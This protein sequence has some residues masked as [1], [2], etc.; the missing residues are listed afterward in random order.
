MK[1]SKNRIRINRYFP[2]SKL[3]NIEHYQGKRRYHM[4]NHYFRTQKVKQM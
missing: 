1:I 3:K 4:N 2:K